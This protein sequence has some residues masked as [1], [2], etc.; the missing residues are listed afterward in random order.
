MSSSGAI[1][2]IQS[3]VLG[4]TLVMTFWALRRRRL[5]GFLFAA[6]GTFAALFLISVPSLV[7]EFGYEVVADSVIVGLIGSICLIAAVTG[8][9]VVLGDSHVVGIR[10]PIEDARSIWPSY[11]MVMGFCVLLALSI[12][13]RHGVS[14][15]AGTWEDARAEATLLDTLANFLQY[16]LFPAAWV[17]Y[18]CGRRFLSILLLIVALVSFPVF[19]ARAALLALPAAIGIDLLRSQLT[20]GRVYLVIFS[21][22]GCGLILHIVGRVLR[23]LGLGGLYLILSGQTSLAMVAEDIVENVDWTGGE[24]EI[25]RYYVYVVGHG[26]FVGATPLGS[27][28]RWLGMY[29]PRWLAPD[30]KPEDVTYVLWRHATNDGVFDAYPSIDQLVAL[31]RGGDTGSIHPTLW[32]EMW[33]NGGWSA[34]PVLACLLAVIVVAIERFFD[35]APKLV[36]ALVAPATVVGYMMVARGNSVIGLG[37]SFYLVPIALGM[38]LVVSA[39]NAVILAAPRSFQSALK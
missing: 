2:V 32:G 17:T 36:A 23:G 33:V 16:F 24:A 14:L 1:V 5:Y 31:L 25:L 39:I 21:L 7:R 28:I 30:T 27:A 11:V 22:L 26:D 3:L 20:R 35:A 34:I 15:V 38:Y 8:L 4:L 19:G 29:L 9:E 10:N 18:R 6:L 12:V 13:A 37:L